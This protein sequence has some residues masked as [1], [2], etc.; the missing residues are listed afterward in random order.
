MYRSPVIELNAAVAIGMA[1]SLELGLIAVE[2]AGRSGQLETYYLFHAARA[3][4]LR[5]LGRGSE[6]RTAYSR[7]LELVTNQVE[8]RYL[9]RRL[10]EPDS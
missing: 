8:R 9:S 4:L 10:R 6:A 1:E 5:R 7:A 3:E 2:E